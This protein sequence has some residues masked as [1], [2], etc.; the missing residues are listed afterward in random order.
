MVKV[1][2]IESYKEYGKCVSIS[3][4]V[5][6]AYVTVDV[7]PRIIK[8]G[9][10][11]GQNF[12][13]DN[14][15]DLGAKPYD[16]VYMDLFGENRR[17]E[18]MGG[19]RIWLS[20]ESYPETYTPDDKPVAY[21]VTE[22]GAVFTPCED[23]PIGVQKTLE[24]KMDADDTNM[25]VI[26]QV[27]N[28]SAAPKEFAVW[29]LSVCAKGGTLIVPTNTNDTGLL[30]NRKMSIW[31]YTDMTDD[32]LYFGKKY[33]T[34]RQDET[35]SGPAKLGFDLNG[36]TAY[37]VLGDE[38]LCKKYDTNHPDGVYPDG[39]CSFE[40]YDCAKMI[41]FETLGELK[42]V[43][44]GQTSELIELWSLCNKPCDVDFKNDESI[45]NLLAKI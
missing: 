3:N 33:V 1:T 29:A 38:I 15:T 11:D 12:M 7:G 28:V 22:N 6:E 19:H 5:I 45:D 42:K 30:P 18:N 34:L 8:F 17:W 41:E 43:G 35:A 4:G 14:R 21:E 20:P 40:T 27:K 39:G 44:S 13:N 24:I 9:Y 36:G 31:P 32:R 37:Y 10:K 2:E 26:M 23:T 25:Q 16:K